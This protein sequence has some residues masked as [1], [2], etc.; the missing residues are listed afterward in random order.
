[1]RSSK[2][3]ECSVNGEGS[4]R[5][6]CKEN[7]VQRESIFFS[8][9]EFKT[10]KLKSPVIIMSEVPVSTAKEMDSLILL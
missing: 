1:M 2:E 7:W 10:L 6:R 3:E 5:S 9:C 4:V 8:A